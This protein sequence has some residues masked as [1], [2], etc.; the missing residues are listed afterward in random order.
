MESHRKNS[1]NT[2]KTEKSSDDASTDKIDTNII[3]ELSTLVKRVQVLEGFTTLSSTRVASGV[4][5]Y[6]RYSTYI[7]YTSSSSPSGPV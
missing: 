7:V 6:T 4:A 2:T 1:A 3:K 5:A